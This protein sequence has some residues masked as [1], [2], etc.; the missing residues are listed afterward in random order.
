MKRYFQSE[1]LSVLQ[2]IIESI[3]ATDLKIDAYMYVD[4]HYVSN[5]FNEVKAMHERSRSRS[6]WSKR[7]I[8]IISLIS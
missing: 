1:Y 3:E 2:V 7:K 4:H 6:S 8:P 5:R